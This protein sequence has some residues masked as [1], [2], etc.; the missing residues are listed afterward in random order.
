[1]TGATGA[2][3]RRR[4]IHGKAVTR[5]YKRAGLANDLTEGLLATNRGLTFNSLCEM[6]LLSLFSRFG[7]TEAER[8][9]EA[10]IELEQPDFSMLRPKISNK[11]D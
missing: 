2:T 7:S 1:M 3:Q 11:V 6:A 4:D 8:K 9:L 10:V 5:S